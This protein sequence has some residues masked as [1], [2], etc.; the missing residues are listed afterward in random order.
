[1]FPS[2][3][4]QRVSL[5]KYSVP[6][7]E[8]LS[9]IG[10]YLACAHNA[11]MPKSLLR[12]SRR[13]GGRHVTPDWRGVSHGPRAPAPASARRCLQENQ[14]LC[15]LVPFRNCPERARRP[16]RQRVERLRAGAEARK[17]VRRPARSCTLWVVLPFPG[18]CPE[19]TL[20]PLERYTRRRLAF[21]Q[22]SQRPLQQRRDCA[23]RASI[24]H[25]DAA[26]QERDQKQRASGQLP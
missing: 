2:T 14:R 22:S 13:T 8:S 26:V 10:A 11:R 6:G 9:G 12:R 1:L 21:L 16:V 17:A 7:Q 19:S 25:Y 20:L 5:T 4:P 3:A 18:S 15:A 24:R 23:H